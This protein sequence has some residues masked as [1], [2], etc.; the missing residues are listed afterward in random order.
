[1]KKFLHRLLFAGLTTVITV[2]FSEKAFWYVQGY[3]YWELILY[4]AFPVFACLWLIEY[5]CVRRLSSLVFVAAFYAFLIEGV[6]TPV[7]YEAGILDPFL[8]AYFVCWHGL[9]SIVFGWYLVRKWL[10]SGMWKRLL[11]AGFLFGLFWGIW[12]ITYWLPETYEE[13]INPGQWPVIDFALY[14]FTFTLSLI[15]GHL[16]L[17]LGGWP[18]SFRPTKIEKWVVALFLVALFALNIVPVVPPGILKLGFLLGIIGIFLAINR[19]REGQKT[20]FAELAGPVTVWHALV[21]LII[22]LTAIS[23]YGLATVVDPSP[24]TLHILLEDIPLIQALIGVG[25]FL[26][27]GL[28]TLWPKREQ[29]P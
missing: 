8:P 23:V 18:S 4:Y 13:F 29:Q 14:A 26:W 3:A 21:L 11:L 2:F 17:G 24:E 7:L 27:A 6:L 20:L 19:R 25:F 28:V 5:F 16:M 22:P 10:V 1:M 12:S 9:L 15:I